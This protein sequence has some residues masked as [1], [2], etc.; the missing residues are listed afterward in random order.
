MAEKA[1]ENLDFKIVLTHL[2][3]RESLFKALN[4]SKLHI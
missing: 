3:A 4:C 2:E 1:I